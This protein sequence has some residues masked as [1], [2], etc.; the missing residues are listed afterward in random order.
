MAQTPVLSIFDDRNPRI[1][2]AYYK[3]IY[4]DY[5]QF[6]GTWIYINGNKSLTITFQKKAMVFIEDPNVSYYQD[7]LVAG[8]KYTVN[9]TELI[10]TMNQLSSPSLDVYAY[11]IRSID[12]L[13][14]FS[15][16][17]CS[18]C[19]ANERRVAMKFSDPTRTTVLG[20][21]AQL[22]LRHVI[23]NGVQKIKAIL[24]Q[25]GGVSYILGEEPAYEQFNVP[26]GEY[27]LT[28]VN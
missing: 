20:L 22:V 25:D 5:T 13:R 6:Q 23:E 26:F 12:I 4:N 2:F 14:S 28:K 18:E 9:G 7:Y 11:N 10:N 21:S 24:W 16:P 27:T 19:S 17:M 1:S 3:D 8:Y 15:V